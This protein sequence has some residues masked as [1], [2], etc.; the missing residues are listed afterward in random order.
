MTGEQR[1]EMNRTCVQCGKNIEGDGIVFCPYCGAKL[2]TASIPEKRNG[3]ETKWIDKALSATSYPERKKI[4]EKGLTACPESREIRWELLF[5]GE[6]GPKKG[7]V[8]DYSVIKCWIMEI[9]WK[10]GDFPEEKRNRMRSELFDA[11]RLQ[12]TL[13]LYDDPER[14]QQEYLQRICREYVEL[15]LEGS[16]QIM[17]NIFGF[18]LERNKDRKLAVPVARMIANIRADEKLSPEQREMLWKAMYQAYGARTGGRME[19][20]DAALNN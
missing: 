1:C 17:G 11:P 12:E 14:K 15:F 3:E 2:E 10:P 6:E 13:A 8:I 18:Q 16:N 4:L 20:L 9:Y 7:K 5:I 19:H